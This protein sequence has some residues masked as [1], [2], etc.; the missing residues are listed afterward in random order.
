[1]FWKKK[2]Q[3]QEKITEKPVTELS[4][5]LAKSAKSYVISLA[6][7]ASCSGPVK[8]YWPGQGERIR[9]IVT[10]APYMSRPEGEGFTEAEAWMAAATSMYSRESTTILKRIFI[11]GE[12]ITPEMTA[13]VKLLL[14]EAA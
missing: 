8:M 5:E 6:P 13:R 4:G 2:K 1:M 9:Y 14:R 11:K 7:Q 3:A 12:A 10:A